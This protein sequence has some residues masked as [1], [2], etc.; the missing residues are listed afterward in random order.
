MDENARPDPPDPEFELIDTGIFDE[1]RYFDVQIEYAKVAPDDILIR[2]RVDNRGPE[3]VAAASAADA[4]VPQ[5]VV[6][7][8]HGRRL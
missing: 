7:G 3:A 1:A 8:A 2:L 5:H 4:L 6:V